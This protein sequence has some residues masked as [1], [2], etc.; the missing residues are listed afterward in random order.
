[1]TLALHAP[2]NPDLYPLHPNKDHIHLQIV[3]SKIYIKCY[4]KVCFYITLN[5][6]IVGLCNRDYWVEYRSL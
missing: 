3:D 4:E 2:H 1:M 5:F 6:I